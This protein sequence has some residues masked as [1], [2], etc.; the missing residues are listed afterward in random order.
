MHTIWSLVLFDIDSFSHSQFSMPTSTHTVVAQLLMKWNDPST[1]QKE[2]L[3]FAVN[4]IRQCSRDGTVAKHAPL[5]CIVKI[6]QLY[7]TDGRVNEGG[8]SEK[9]KQSAINLIL[10]ACEEARRSGLIQSHSFTAEAARSLRSLKAN[11]EC[12]KLV[13]SLLSDAGSK[14]RHRIAMVEGI[15]AA[16][17]ERDHDSLQLLTDAFERSGYDLR[18]ISLESVGSINRD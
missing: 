7:D 3:L 6:A 13:R 14:V 4:E 1:S 11:K 9:Q 15:R 17:E 16:S 18:R 12:V 5:M 10:E 2:E 8:M